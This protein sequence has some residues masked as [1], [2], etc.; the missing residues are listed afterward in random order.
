M[1]FM[2]HSFKGGDRLVAKFLQRCLWA[3]EAM[4]PVIADNIQSFYMDRAIWGRARVPTS[5][6][7]LEEIFNSSTGATAALGKLHVRN[8]LRLVYRSAT[9]FSVTPGS[10][11]H[12]GLFKVNE[13]AD[14]NTDG[15]CGDELTPGELLISGEC[16]SDEGNPSGLDYGDGALWYYVYAKLDTGT[17]AMEFRISLA[18]PV[19]CD[20]YGWEHPANNK[21]AYLGALRTI[22]SGELRAWMATDDGWTYWDAVA[23]ATDDQAAGYLKGGTSVG[24][25]TGFETYVAA[26]TGGNAYHDGQKHI[27]PT[28]RA[29]RVGYHQD[30]ETT[31]SAQLKVRPCSSAGAGHAINS[32]DSGNNSVEVVIPVNMCHLATASR[33]TFEYSSEGGGDGDNKLD[34]VGY[35]EEN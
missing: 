23:V 29:I 25:T 11:F 12:R 28:A 33:Q 13:I 34:V 17:S 21:L 1:K 18:E 24:N 14:C 35:Y 20:G 7:N 8:G 19:N 5:A 9:T 27:P 15:T 31:E 3:V 22:A 32:G 16:D 10:M 26:N 30:T 6:L 2:P 4:F